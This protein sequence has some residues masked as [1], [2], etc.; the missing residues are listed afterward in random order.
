MNV[1]VIYDLINVCFFCVDFFLGIFM[2]D[3]L[4]REGCVYL[5]IE[6]LIFLRFWVLVIV[7]KLRICLIVGIRSGIFL[8]IVINFV[9]CI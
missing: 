4:R 3:L 1:C 6:V 5:K 8:N 7:R 2:V 9:S